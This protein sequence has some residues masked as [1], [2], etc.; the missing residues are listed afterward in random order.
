MQF[1]IVY[2]R[3]KMQLLTLRQFANEAGEEA[4]AEKLALEL[5]FANQPD[6]EVAFF[7]SDSLDTLQRTHG[8]YFQSISELATGVEKALRA[9]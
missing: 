4:R 9:S 5:E 3:S 6:V 2:G 8:R 7:Q 1:I